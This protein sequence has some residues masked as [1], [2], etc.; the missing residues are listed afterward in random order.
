[1]NESIEQ[2]AG[3]NVRSLREEQHLS[4]TAFCLMAGVSR[5]YLN[6]IEAGQANMSIKQLDRLAKALGTDV[7]SL[8]R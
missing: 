5:P 6:R 1:M 7:I 2:T 8:L 3:R 4:K